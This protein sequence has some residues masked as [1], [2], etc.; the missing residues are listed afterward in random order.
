MEDLGTKVKTRIEEKVEESGGQIQ[1]FPERCTQAV[2]WNKNRGWS[3]GGGEVGGPGLMW[4]SRAGGGSC[5]AATAVE[6]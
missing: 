2:D 1:G 6:V 5:H 3:K 4:Q